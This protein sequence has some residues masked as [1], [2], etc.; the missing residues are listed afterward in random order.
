MKIKRFFAGLLTICLIAAALC[1]GVSAETASGSCGDN[2]TWRFDSSTGTLTISG[3]GTATGTPGDS[4]KEFR[5]YESEILH[6]VFEEGI[7]AIGPSSF[8]NL[9]NLK[10]IKIADS[11]KTIGEM[12]FNTCRNLT[13][14][15]LGNGVTTIESMAFDYA[16]SLKTV[17]LPQSIKSLGGQIFALAG[18]TGI[19]FPEGITVISKGIVR[20]CDNLTRVYIPASV[21]TVDYAAFRGCKALTDVY[22][23]GTPE[24]WEAIAIDDNNDDPYRGNNEYLLAATIHYNH[25]HSWNSGSTTQA[26]N[27]QQTGKKTVS[28]TVC[29]AA[30]TETVSKTGHSWDS[31]SVTASATCSKDGSKIYT[32]SVCKTTK[33]ETIS[34]TGHNWDSGTKNA[35]TTVSYT[36]TKCSA[37]KIEGTPVATTQPTAQETTAETTAATVETTAETSAGA[38]APDS[39]VTDQT[40]VPEETG[41]P[42]DEAMPEGGFP[43]WIVIVGVV[44]LAAGGVGLWFWLKKKK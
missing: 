4:S 7:T 1:P 21:T 40:T 26:A 35:D 10:S 42:T 33:T 20:N 19:A 12:A 28:C 2:A 37:I 24:Q 13:D 36:C 5:Q 25:S 3:T 6:L 29:P 17:I 18:L 44:I 30:K 15:D 38:E 43:W 22:Y 9:Y 8:G 16:E 31:G 11:V 34:K 41:T 27:C 32:C 39:P 14:L 23:G